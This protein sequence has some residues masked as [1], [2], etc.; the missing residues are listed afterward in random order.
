[1]DFGLEQLWEAGWIWAIARGALVTIAIGV[2]S[3]VIGLILGMIGGLIKWARL[4]P[5]TLIVDAYTLI[6]RGVPELLIIYLLFFGSVEFV[7]RIA[8][9]FGY[10]NGADNGYAF[11]VGVAAI[12]VISGAYSVEVIRGALAAIP[13]GQVEA[14]RALGIR[15]WR[16]F[17]RIIVPQMTRLAIPGVNNVWQTTIKDTALVSVVG[18]QELMRIS[19]VG[20]GSTRQPFLFYAV[21]AAIYFAITLVSQALFD[22]VERRLTLF[23][24]G[25]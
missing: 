20:A 17:M 2:S 25:K 19:F 7:M 24:R 12:S 21:A 5:L 3:M 16:I 13:N 18:L 15:R 11:I 22:G 14:A 10:E 6:V 8:T 1:M 23:T 9:V 4:F